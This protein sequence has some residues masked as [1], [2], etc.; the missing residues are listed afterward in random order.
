MYQK[1]RTSLSRTA[2]LAALA[3]ATLA[4]AC[5]DDGESLVILQNQIPGDGCVVPPGADAEFRASGAVETRSSSGYLF[6]PVVESLLEKTDVNARTV[7]MRGADVDVT[8]PDGFFSGSEEADLRDRALTR[9]SQS[10]TGSL[11]AKATASFAFVVLPGELLAE[12]GDKLDSD[13]KVRAIVE[14]VVFGDLRGGE[15]ESVPFTYPIDVCVDCL[16]T[17]RGECSSLSSSFMA[18]Q[19]NACNPHQDDKV[20]CCTID[21]EEVCP[22]V[23]TAAPG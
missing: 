18:R 19:G 15:V 20:D 3:I 17:D 13:E 21:G 8:F 4:G 5:T 7:T 6:T 11:P 10:F 16:V 23:G 1:Q 22:A 12:V 2:A 14:V 9:F